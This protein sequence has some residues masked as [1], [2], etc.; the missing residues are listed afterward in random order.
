[1]PGSVRVLRLDTLTS[2]GSRAAA[3]VAKFRDELLGPL[4]TYWWVRIGKF[5]CK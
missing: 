5:V 3:A 1:M 2:C 4:T